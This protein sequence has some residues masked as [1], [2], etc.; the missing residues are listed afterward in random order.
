MEMSAYE[1]D[2]E[3]RARNDQFDSLQ[4]KCLLSFRE[5]SLKNVMHVKLDALKY[6]QVVFSLHRSLVPLH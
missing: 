3:I 2:A 4:R 6:L 1:V 5:F